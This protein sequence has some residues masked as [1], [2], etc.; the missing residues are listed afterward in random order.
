MDSK[1]RGLVMAVA[2][3]AVIAMMAVAIVGVVG[4][5]TSLGGG[6]VDSPN[7]VSKTPTIEELY[8]AMK[9]QVTVADPVK[10]PIDLSGS[11]LYD[12]LP[13]ITKYPLAVE[14]NADIVLEI[15][16]SP[17]K[18]GSEANGES[19]LIDIANDF[20]RKGVVTSSGQSCGIAVRSVTSG[21]AA[22]YII[23]GKYVPELFTPS[24][25]VWGALIESNGR[26]AKL[27]TERLVGNTAGVMIKKS[28]GYDNV[29]AIIEAAVAGK[30]NL[31]YTN[32]QVSS[33]GVNMLLT[34]LNKYDSSDLL[35]E[36]AVSG[37]TS[38][39]KNIP[40]V[41]YNTNQ[42]VQSA[43]TG[44]L[45][46]M[47]AEYQGYVN[48]K[49]FVKE[50]EFIPYGI[51]HD[52]PLYSCR[53][54]TSDERECLDKFLEYALGSNAQE[55]ATQFGFNALDNYKSAFE[56]PSGSTVSEAVKI[57]KT[58][59]D[60]G[61]EI[62]CV[63]VADCSGSMDGE[64]IQ[65]L[66]T[67]LTNG[68][69][70]IGEDNYV[71]LVSYSSGVV[72]ELPIGKFDM[73]QRAYFQGAVESLRANGNTHTYEALALAMKMLEDEKMNHPNA[74]FMIFLLSDGAANGHWRLSDIE[75]TL[76]DSGYPVYTI[77]YGAG[78][79]SAELAKV[80]NV[81]EAAA[82]TADSEDVVYKLKSL[83]NAQL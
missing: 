78:A 49:E 35:S 71:G 32:P 50:Y 2:I 30:L 75:Y 51:R 11:S 54:L 28:L 34:V 36:T 81:N 8:E 41:A 59:K 74:K 67:S 1:K 63:F 73:N 38:F 48:N 76:A 43:G 53:N 64:P 40:Y 4:S 69:Q 6:G 42:M 19:W 80:S 46:C 60:V 57:W 9:S 22:D 3:F 20:N 66:R 16:S 13:E 47:I 44:A 14:P 12:E 62:V 24:S 18:A 77:S 61:K 37:F 7:K 65:Q 31:G 70:Y 10:A 45:D 17:E 79:D 68:A 26:V 27:E 83:F 39:Q 21:L 58:N 72:K 33:G 5:L 25:D 52:N 55:R 29:D 15:F 23:S 82:I 56:C